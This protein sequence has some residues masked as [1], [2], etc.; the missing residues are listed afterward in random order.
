[1]DRDGDGD[2]SMATT[3]GAAIDFS[4]G[5]SIITS[6]GEAMVFSS[7]ITATSSSSDMMDGDGVGCS[8]NDVTK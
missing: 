4:S 2:S 7:W 5:L 3:D 8:M 1:M 6:S